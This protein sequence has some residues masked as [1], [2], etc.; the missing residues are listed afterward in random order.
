MNPRLV[1]LLTV[2]E[3]MEQGLAKGHEPDGW[4]QWPAGAHLLKSARHNLTAEGLLRY[5]EHFTDLEDALTH[6][7]QALVRATF[8][9]AVI[10]EM[11]ANGKES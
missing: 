1:A 2:E 8:A 9:V 7:K 5:P 6:A 11:L 3:I 4:R 10:E